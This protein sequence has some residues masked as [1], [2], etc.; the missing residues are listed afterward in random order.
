MN[1]KQMKTTIE[2]DS[3]ELER[4]QKEILTK[5][6]GEVESK[7]AIELQNVSID[8]GETLAVDDVSFKIPEGKLIT[9]LGPSGSGKTTTLNAI[10]GLLTITGGKIFFKGKD[11]TKLSPQRRKLGFVFQNYALY[12]HMS[13]YD[14]IAFPLKNDE[15]WQSKFKTKKIKAILDIEAIYLKHL[16]ASE[17]ELNTIQNLFKVYKELPKVADI[18]Y[19]NYISESKYA[20]ES[21]K[22]NFKIS[23]IHYKSDK[24]KN[25][26]SIL[27]SLENSKR[28]FAKQKRDIARK[29]AI[30]KANGELPTFYEKS[31][32]LPTIENTMFKQKY[33][34]NKEELIAKLESLESTVFKL[35]TEDRE[36]F[37][38][39][40]QLLSSK[41][42]YKLKATRLFYK[43]LIN[44]KLEIE[45]HAPLI[46]KAKEL[47]LEELKKFNEEKFE[48]KE[49]TARL[50]RNLNILPS[51]AKRK[52]DAYCKEIAAKYDLKMVMDQDKKF[53]NVKLS[54]DDRNK[55]FELNK[56]VI[57][58][59]DAIHNEVMEVAEKVDIKKILAK[60]PTRLSGGQQQRV[61]IAR[62]IVKKPSILL[63]DE[64]LSNLDAKLRI[65][66]RQWIRD[67]QKSLG[68]TTVFVTHDQE[69]AMSISDIVICMSTSKVQQI[70]SPIEL[71]KKPSNLF[72]ARF[73]GMPEMGILKGNITSNGLNILN[74]NFPSIVVKGNTSS[75]IH[76]GIRAEDIM[77]CDPGTLNSFTGT[78]HSVENYGKES[79]LIVTVDENGSETNINVLVDNSKEFMVGE[80]ISFTIPLDKLNIFDVE[81]T[82]RLNYENNRK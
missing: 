42:E 35:T 4:L 71:Y 37:D 22:T 19:S 5:K 38:Q 56:N 61:A 29:F 44:N 48:V 17:E 26:Q 16:G 74:T 24:N 39:K 76:V 81:T 65:S 69:E 15:I 66:T 41:I 8:F 79:K 14:N 30:L 27:E 53:N 58:L 11:V 32:V 54:D 21:A 36:K 34:E 2:L 46:A 6:E 45:K 73:L 68:I 12:P 10:S 47:Y 23:E 49:K 82:L 7:P 57:S 52:L 72:V 9:L 28:H 50:L 51:L 60:R 55:I 80:N 33:I 75:Q 3:L 62:A 31:V 70:G 77:L 40:E 25:A 63:M 67:I 13:V 64:P 43:N 20:L 1:E 78:I 18:E 59:S